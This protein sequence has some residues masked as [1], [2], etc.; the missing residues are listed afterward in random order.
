VRLLALLLLAS[1]CW[2]QYTVPLYTQSRSAGG[3][4]NPAVV[5]SKAA[6]GAFATNPSTSAAY[7]S[8]VT[9]GNILVVTVYQSGGTINTPTGSGAGCTTLTYTSQGTPGHGMN[10]WTAT[11]G[12]TGACTISD[13]GTSTGNVALNLVVVEIS[14]VVTTTPVVSAYD[15]IGACSSCTG[16]GLTTSVGN[17]MVLTFI[18]RSAGATVSAP[19]PFSFDINA[20]NSQGAYNGVGHYLLVAAGS[21]T[22]TWT[23]S[24]SPG[25]SD[26]S[27][28]LHP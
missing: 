20:N 19:S 25:F 15:A 24:G 17:S 1:P 11:A 4:A 12:A 18:M 23:A 8:N 9:S 13:T 22:P 2:A 27:I 3:A 7:T 16:T 10:I 21:Y 14:G 28:A 6:A 5:Q 26:V